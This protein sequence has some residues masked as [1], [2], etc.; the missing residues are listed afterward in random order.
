MVH[1]PV[2]RRL[3]VMPDFSITRHD[4]VFRT[5]AIAEMVLRLRF[6]NAA[7]KTASTASVAK[8]RDQCARA[9]A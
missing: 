7:A 6:L 4:A 8:P 9:T 1:P 2:S 3:R 5:S